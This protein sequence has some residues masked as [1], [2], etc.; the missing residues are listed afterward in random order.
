MRKR[1][2]LV[3]LMLGPV[4]LE[5]RFRW[6]WAAALV[7]AAVV[8]QIG[9]ITWPVF[10]VFDGR[11]PVLKAVVTSLALYAVV[12]VFVVPPVAEAFGRVPLPCATEGPLVPRSWVFCAANRNYVVPEMRAAALEIADGVAGRVPNGSVAYLDGGF[13]FAGPPL[14]PHLSHGDGRKLDLALVFEGDTGVGGSPIGYFGYIQ[15]GSSRAAACPERWWDL[16]W[17]F[18]WAQGILVDEALDE[19][20]TRSLLRA[21]VAHPAVGKVLLE[22]HLQRR[23]GVTSPKLRFQG[24]H[25][26]R[27]DDH[28]HIQLRP[29]DE[30]R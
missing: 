7:A 14:L 26:A 27:H 2:L 28:M 3:R 19:D 30:R 1:P 8:T 9:A 6:V 17:D 5:T 22:P 4:G 29:V 11:R 10:G 25:A 24:C 18:D 12:T 20:R 21:A 13:P 15:P 23:L 16:R